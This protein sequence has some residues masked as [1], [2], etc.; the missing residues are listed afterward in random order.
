MFGLLLILSKNS[1]DVRAFYINNCFASNVYN[2][3]INIEFFLS[4][5]DGD[6]VSRKRE[7][8]EDPIEEVDKFLAYPL[9]ANS[10]N[11]ET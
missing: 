6:G 4:P 11:S 5:V 3:D 1:A 7:K 10:S 8:R 9:T 2:G